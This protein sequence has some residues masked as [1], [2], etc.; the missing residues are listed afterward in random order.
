MP[1]NDTTNKPL[2]SRPPPDDFLRIARRGDLHRFPRIGNTIAAK[3]V[4][5]VEAKGSRTRLVVQPNPASEHAVMMVPEQSALRVILYT[6]TG[7]AVGTVEGQL[8][9]GRHSLPCSVEDLPAGS[10][11]VELGAGRTRLTQ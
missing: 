7:Q 9:R 5:T 6:V 3:A 2:P 1:A 10:Y 11:L 8:E 4:Q